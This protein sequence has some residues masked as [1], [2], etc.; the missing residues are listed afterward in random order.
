MKKSKKSIIFKAIKKNLKLRYIIILIVLLASNSFA[1][2]IYSSAIEGSVDVHVKAWKV[3]FQSGDTEVSSYLNIDI[4]A[5]YPGMDNFTKE[6]TAYNKSELASKITYTLLEANIMGDKYITKEGKI[7]NGLDLDGTEQTSEEMLEK[8]SNKYPFKITMSVDKES[9]EPY[10]G[11]ATY[12]LIFT[13]PFESN[14]DA[15]DTKYGEK[16]YD[17]L[18]KNPGKPCISLKV[19]IKIEQI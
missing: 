1:W 16:A 19:L 13:W 14:N 10:N 18:E 2:F 12:R 3:V 8:F 11:S 5:A 15:L 17:F 7:E 6:L 4:D 9:M